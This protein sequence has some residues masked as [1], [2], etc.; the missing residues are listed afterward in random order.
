MRNFLLATAALST[1][2][3]GVAATAVEAAPIAGVQAIAQ[4]APS[5]I[6]NVYWRRV[7]DRDGDR[8]HRVW[9]HRRWWRDRN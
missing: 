8:C 4:A 9:I 6:D 5:N 2:A 7:C 1:L 3:I